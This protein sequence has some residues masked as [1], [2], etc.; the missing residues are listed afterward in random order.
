MDDGNLQDFLQ[1]CFDSSPPISQDYA[2]RVAPARM[3][4]RLGAISAFA[5]VASILVTIPPYE[6]FE[7]RIS[8]FTFTPGA[9]GWFLVLRVKGDTSAIRDVLAAKT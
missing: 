7:K 5:G 4:G 2:Q 3:L 1:M 6:L 8:V 9:M